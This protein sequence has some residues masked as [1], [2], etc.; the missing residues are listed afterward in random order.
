ML[1]FILKYIIKRTHTYFQKFYKTFNIYIPQS[2]QKSMSS[3]KCHLHYFENIIIQTSLSS[4]DK[5][6]W[7][8]CILLKIYQVLKRQQY[9]TN[10]WYVQFCDHM[11]EYVFLWLQIHGWYHAQK[12]FFH[13]LDLLLIFPIVFWIMH[14]VKQC[15]RHIHFPSVTFRSWLK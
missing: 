8:I 4:F 7:W 9:K 12:M 11:T 5:F 6:F 14:S 1:R 10:L 3:K 15:A 13:N 2:A